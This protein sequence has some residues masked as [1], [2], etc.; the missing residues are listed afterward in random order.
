MIL[1][2]CFTA[3]PYGLLAHLL[4]I[5][6]TAA[7]LVCIAVLFSCSKSNPE[8]PPAIDEIPKPPVTTGD[9]KPNRSPEGDVVGK[10]VVG[11]QGW[12]GAAG[13]KSPFNSWRHWS[14]Q[15]APRKDNQSFELWPD[16]SE[17]ENQY[18]TGYAVLNNGN[19]AQIF[20]S[21]DDQTVD[22][23]FEWMKKYEIHC[24][25]LQRFG[26]S[27]YKDARDKGF[28][29]GTAEKVRKAAE[30]YQRKFYLMYDISGWDNFQT[31]LKKD[32][33]EVMK[34]H[35]ES[36][37]Y[38]RQNGK[39]VVC[40]WGIGV[41]NRP[42]D[43]DSWKEV[44]NWFKDQNYYV[45]IGTARNWREQTA[46]LPAY[47]AANMISPWSVG[48]YSNSAG[49]D[50]YAAV[51]QADL[52][53]LDGKGQDFQPVVFPGFAWSNWKSNP[54]NQIPRMHGDFMWNQF[55]NIKQ[56]AIPNVYVAMFDEYD[57]ATAIAKAA[58]DISTIPSDQY[59]LTLD[60]DGVKCSS[61][62]YLR[63]TRDGAKM[64][65][66]ALPFSVQHPTP[67]TL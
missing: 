59:F 58:E 56:K 66:G 17:Y 26:G 7:L 61:D 1:L 10:L 19:P 52:A 16:L 12:F 20:S 64:I 6:R 8:I 35:T 60:A 46:N 27:L 62:F 34:K 13:D 4:K 47:Q 63:L 25:A 53:Y 14:G 55:A 3:K 32:W 39:P 28:R 33:T 65:N 67:H 41:A 29:D 21:W 2:S 54:R 18:P 11:Y 40:I 15:G 45:I 57:E 5:H 37:A 44:I 30:K 24:A 23:H 49:V 36:T 43:V 51:L 9:P 38:A 50:T 22:K 31:E 48:T 42:G